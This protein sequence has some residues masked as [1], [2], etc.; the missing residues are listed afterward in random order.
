[1][2]SFYLKTW[3]SH[4]SRRGRDLAQRNSHGDQLEE[5]QEVGAELVV[6]SGDAAE[7][8]ELVEEALDLI[9]LR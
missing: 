4:Q 5:R 7:L 9:R 3:C 1:M 8:F 6:S 2:P